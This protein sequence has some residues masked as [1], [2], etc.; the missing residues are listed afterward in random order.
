MLDDSGRTPLCFIRMCRGVLCIFSFRAQRLFFLGAFSFWP[1]AVYPFI[2]YS[3]S[4][5]SGEKPIN[6]PIKGSLTR[7]LCPSNR[8]AV[9]LILLLVKRN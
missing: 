3:Y 5:K 2:N 9:G 8:E 1:P 4:R 7:F 6:K